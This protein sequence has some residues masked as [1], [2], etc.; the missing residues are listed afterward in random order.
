MK[1]LR[2]KNM[3]NILEMVAQQEGVSVDEV[4]TEM[5]LAIE[6][7]RNN[8]DP[9]KQANFKKMFGNSTPTP[10][11]FISKIAKSTVK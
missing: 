9:E 5:E 1:I 3:K 6:A 10:E 4:R 7:A 8:P 2:K 11:E